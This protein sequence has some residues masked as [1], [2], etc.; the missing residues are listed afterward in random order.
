MTV[1]MHL[2]VVISIY[3]PTVVARSAS[4]DPA[5][6]RV[7]FADGTEDDWPIEDLRKPSAQKGRSEL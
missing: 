4:G 5:E 1:I 6:L 2:K 3:A 7:R